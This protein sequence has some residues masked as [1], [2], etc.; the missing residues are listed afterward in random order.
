MKAILLAKKKKRT[1]VSSTGGGGSNARTGTDTDR[2]ADTD[3][4]RDT[5]AQIAVEDGRRSLQQVDF[6]RAIVKALKDGKLMWACETHL[7][8][9][10]YC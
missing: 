4:D 6:D 5:D 7:L 2:D 1:L 9:V 10:E 3:T 8:V